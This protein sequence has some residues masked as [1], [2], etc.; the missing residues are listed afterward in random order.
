LSTVTIPPVPHA[1]I[2]VLLLQYSLNT[3]IATNN[4]LKMNRSEIA[5]TFSMINICL[6]CVHLCIHQISSKSC[7]IK[8]FLFCLWIVSY[9]NGENSKRCHPSYSCQYETISTVLT[10]QRL[11][12]DVSKKLLILCCSNIMVDVF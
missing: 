2:H 11:C 12:F 10:F 4:H 3:D 9:S 8:Y 6:P 7:K 1:V 5:V